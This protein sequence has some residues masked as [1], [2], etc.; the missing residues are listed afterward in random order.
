MA[1]FRLYPRDIGGVC[2]SASDL[3]NPKYPDA[4]SASGNG[5]LIMGGEVED[6]YWK[7]D[8]TTA[9]DVT[10]YRASTAKPFG[11]ELL[12][13][14]ASEADIVGFNLYRTAQGGSEEQVNTQGLITALTPGDASGNAYAFYDTLAVPA[15]K[16]TYR[17]EIVRAGAN[18]ADYASIDG[19]YFNTF[20]PVIH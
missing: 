19:W 13:N 10:D 15:V 9:A 3:N 4:G 7:I 11:L 8:G 2:D 5:V 16:Y 18:N 14:T 1:R 20:I 17:L 12:W 6:Y